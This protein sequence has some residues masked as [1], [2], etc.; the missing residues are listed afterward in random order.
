MS[1]ERCVPVPLSVFG[2]GYAAKAGSANAVSALV[3]ERNWGL[4]NRVRK[5][6]ADGQEWIDCLGSAGMRLPRGVM[7][8]RAVGATMGAWRIQC[9]NIADGKRLG[10]R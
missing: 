1:A 3:V 7:H 5:S 10:A 8:V 9:F 6:A 2:F 4:Q